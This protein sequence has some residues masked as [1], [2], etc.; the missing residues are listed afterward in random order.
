VERPQRR[1]KKRGRLSASG[2]GKK[3][4]S[5]GGVHCEKKGDGKLLRRDA[6]SPERGRS[7]LGHR[8]E[9]KRLFWGINLMV[10]LEKKGTRIICA[11]P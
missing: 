2:E 7:A 5:V 3:G 11:V 1:V 6:R 8:K 4:P 10:G 9:E